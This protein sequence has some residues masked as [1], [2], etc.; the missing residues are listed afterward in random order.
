MRFLG[1]RQ[2]LAIAV[3]VA[4]VS[5]IAF[6]ELSNPGN[7]VLANPPSYFTV[8]GHTYGITYL[9]TD[10]SERQTG[11]MNRKVTNITTMLFVFPSPGSYSFWMS[12]VNSSLD[13]V[14]LN[15]TGNVGRVV[16]LVSNAPGCNS[17]AFCPTYDP[18]SKA[19]WVLEAK[20]GFAESNGVSIGSSIV[21][22]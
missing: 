10:Q 9:A 4:V 19:N 21:F 20:G 16:Y 8:N 3:V 18:G 6:S 13:I 7:V 5:Y 1:P 14:W 15:V 22:G 2:I 12:N 11:L 17:G